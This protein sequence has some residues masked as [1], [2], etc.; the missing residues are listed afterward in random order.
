MDAI[1]LTSLYSMNLQK[2]QGLEPARANCFIIPQACCISQ[3]QTLSTGTPK[4]A[5]GQQL[6]DCPV[7]PF[8]CL[9]YC[10]PTFGCHPLPH[11]RAER[12]RQAHHSLVTSSS[13]SYQSQPILA[14]SSRRVPTLREQHAHHSFVAPPSGLHQSLSPTAV[15]CWCMLFPGEQRAHHTLMTPLSCLM[16]PLSCLDLDPDLGVPKGRPVPLGQAWARPSLEG[17]LLAL[18]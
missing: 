9:R 17:P 18:T 8:G 10:Q 3:M 7:A 6:E 13:C 11:A 4:P 2:Q 15:R 16:T 1:G 5:A 12:G 14:V